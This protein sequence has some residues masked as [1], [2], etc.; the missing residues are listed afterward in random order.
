M[1]EPADPTAPAPSAPSEEEQA[2]SLV[3]GAWGD[4]SAHRAYLARFVD[5]EGFAVA[6]ARYRAVLAERPQDAVALRMREELLRKATLVGLGSLPRSEAPRRVRR[7]IVVFGLLG[8]IAALA[9]AFVA[10]YRFLGAAS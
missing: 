4:E 5:L 10:L 7:A 6:G 8:A 9:V 2:W 3:L 1:S